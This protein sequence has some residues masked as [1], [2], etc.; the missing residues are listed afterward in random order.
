MS[1]TDRIVR[2]VVGL[3]ALWGGILLAATGFKFWGIVVVV[4]SL[5]LLITALLNT[6]PI[7]QLLGMSTVPTDTANNE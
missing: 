2:Y 5:V 6:C 7:Y 3:I 1:Q 4:I